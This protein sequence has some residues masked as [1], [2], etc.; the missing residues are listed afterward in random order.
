[1]EEEEALSELQHGNGRRECWYGHGT[2]GKGAD[3][4]NCLIIQ[5]GT[6]LRG[7][8][9]GGQGEGAGYKSRRSRLTGT[10]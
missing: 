1:M 10:I 2:Y 4:R 9:N 6:E 8:D 7:D 3:N 5:N